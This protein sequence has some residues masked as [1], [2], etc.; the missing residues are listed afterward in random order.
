MK[1]MQQLAS[2]V[3]DIAQSDEFQ[4]FRV[5]TSDF[6]SARERGE[7]AGTQI[8]Q[9]SVSMNDAAETLNRSFLRKEESG[10]FINVISPVVVPK[11]S[12]S[13]SWIFWIIFWGIIGTIGTVTTAVIDLIPFIGGVTLTFFGPHFWGLLLAYA[14][15][16]WWRNSHVMI[17]DGCKALITR[18]GKLEKIADPGFIWL[19]SPWTN[20]SYIVN[21]TREY[22]YNAPIREAPTAG[23]VNASIDLFLQ[24]RIE[25]PVEFIFTLGGVRGFSEKLEHAISEVTRALIYEQ[26]AENI[27]DMVGES[28]QPLLENLN[29]QFPSVRF[30]NSN[31][32]H[33]EPASQQYRM[34]LAA[35]EMVRVAKEAY[36][37][38]YELKLRKEQDEGAF[39]KELASL[40]ETLSEIRAEI[41]RYQAQMDTAH[42]K[43]VNRANASAGQLMVEAES[44][45]KANAALLEAQ[46]L[47]IRAVSSAYFPEILEYRFQQ[48]ILNKLE[49]ISGQLPQVVQIGSADASIDFMQTARQMLG[50]GDETLYSDADMQVIRERM[51]DILA[52][53]KERASQLSKLVPEET[54]PVVE[55]QEIQALQASQEEEE[56]NGSKRNKTRLFED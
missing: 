54:V 6:I 30:V 49:S 4:Q 53:I 3:A 16:S 32:T 1:K 21:V 18:F 5:N 35:P 56:Q 14:L 52:R 42:E 10:Q 28:T 9:M 15:F 27:Y 26:K 8:V 29:K 31:I 25:D 22:P 39:N 47:D 43:E 12:R 44:E 7:S 55:E 38:E 50:V 17:P 24:F 51:N 2:T 33:A 41:A 40:R 36:T 11:S 48:E 13:Y 37:Y 23:R 34:D 46:A 19:P 45:A 20:V